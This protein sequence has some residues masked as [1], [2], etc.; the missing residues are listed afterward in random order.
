MSQDKFKEGRKH[1]P[2]IINEELCIKCG[3]CVDICPLDVFFG[4]IPG[5]VPKVTY[6]DECWHDGSCVVDC[7]VKGA[8]KLRLPLN[9]SLVYK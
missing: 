7:P 3:T 5:E 8:I 1:M 2:P 6:P 4:S 9:M